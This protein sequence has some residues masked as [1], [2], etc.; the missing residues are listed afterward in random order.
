M[1]VSKDKAEMEY[2]RISVTDSGK[3]ISGEDISKLYVP[4]ER[5]GA[6]SSNI[7]GTGLGLAVVKKLMDAMNG[8]VGVD[9]I[10]GTGSTFWIELPR[11][12]SFSKVVAGQ[13]EESTSNNLSGTQ[14]G[15]ILYIE[16]NVPNAELVQMIMDTCH[17]GVR[18]IISS[19]GTQ[20]VALAK[21]NLPEM[22][23]L[24]LNLPDISGREVLKN[25]KNDAE[26]KEIPVIIVSADAM[27]HQLH[28][29]MNEGATEYLTKPINVEK[30]NS[31]I[32]KIIPGDPTE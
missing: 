13:V 28:A 26:T 7:E 23:L 16:D 10:P 11:S 1:V 31:L 12:Q 19:T 18:L 21:E 9:S 29:L 14:I 27:P 8:N 17:K 24:D 2:V 5:I 22:I 4:F 6:E 30:F 32:N 25:L 20:A 3:G 15:T